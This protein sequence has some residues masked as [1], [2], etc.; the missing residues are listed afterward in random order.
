MMRILEELEQVKSRWGA[1]MNPKDINWLIRQT[2]KYAQLQKRN[3]QLK[4][5]IIKLENELNNKRNVSEREG[6]Q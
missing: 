5:R 2:E 3:E 4:S 6:I 1:E